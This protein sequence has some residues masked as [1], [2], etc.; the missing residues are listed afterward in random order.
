MGCFGWLIF[1][2]IKKG[3]LVL[4]LVNIPFVWFPQR[5]NAFPR[6]TCVFKDENS[7]GDASCQHSELL[8]QS[9]PL[10]N[11]YFSCYLKPTIYGLTI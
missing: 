6:H 1:M 10:L 4:S 3:L 7:R 9:G 5:V 11:P 8:V 2:A